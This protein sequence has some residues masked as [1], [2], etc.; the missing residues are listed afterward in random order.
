MSNQQTFLASF[1]FPEVFVNRR[2]KIKYLCVAVI[3]TYCPAMR[4]VSRRCPSTVVVCLWEVTLNGGSAVFIV[5][6]FPLKM[7]NAWKTT[8]Q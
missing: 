3:M 8:V 6:V 2:L 5:L 1:N 4:V 7:F